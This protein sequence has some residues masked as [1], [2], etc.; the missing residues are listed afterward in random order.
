MRRRFD[1]RHRM[2]RIDLAIRK[3]AVETGLDQ[4]VGHWYKGETMVLLGAFIGML[5]IGAMIP[6]IFGG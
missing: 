4:G 2:Q 5:A 6:W 3:S 1:H